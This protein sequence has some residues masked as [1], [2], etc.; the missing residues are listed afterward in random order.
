VAYAFRL[1]DPRMAY[2]RLSRR[3]IAGE[4]LAL[5]VRIGEHLR[6]LPRAAL[7]NDTISVA[8]DLLDIERALQLSNTA[9]A[10][11]V[12]LRT[13]EAKP[14]HEEPL[15]FHHS[16]FAP[17]V[18]YARTFPHSQAAPKPGL[19]AVFTHVCDDAA[20]LRLWERHYARLAGQANLFVIDHGSP[21][22]P[23]QLLHPETNL[24]RLPRGETDH[25]D[26]ARFCGWFQRFLLSQYRAVLHTDVDELVVHQDGNAA[27]LARLEAGGALG[28]LTPEH[29]VD[30]VQNLGREAPLRLE[31]P[32]GAQRRLML[33][34]GF[35]RK[36]VLADEPV[37]WG[38][39]FHQAFE[40]SRIRTEPGLWL[41]HLHS[42]DFDLL[43]RKNRKWKA[44]PQSRADSGICPHGD[45]PD[46]PEALQAWYA[47][48]L[49]DPRLT[50]IPPEL[51]RL[52]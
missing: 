27:L 49:A 42:V 19:L 3:D 7:R 46:T 32:I 35:Y 6:P 25:A 18:D 28:V 12:V 10:H 44:L 51:R 23:R 41:L 14:L 5:C 24:V 50:A 2:I 34:D 9:Q 16:F 39:G 38:Q 48:S 21:V 22:S 20:M 11:V 4:G 33:P 43:L 29:A 17:I 8:D 30:V 13:G 26:M 40:E 52:F 31:E 47:R 45:R 36:P 15:F 1:D 37:S